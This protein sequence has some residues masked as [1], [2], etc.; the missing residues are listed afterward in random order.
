MPVFGTLTPANTG[1]V[2]VGTD[3]GSPRA[4]QNVIVY[5]GG[6]MRATATIAVRRGCDDELMDTR[7][8]TV[9]ANSVI[10]VNGLSPGENDCTSDRT[11][12]YVRYT[13]ITVDQP[14]LSVVSALAEA[15]PRAPDNV[16]P[17]V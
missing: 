8:V 3:I 15:Q 10:Q 17:L 13:V 16:A 5:N 1:Q 14:S 7:T 11:P 6:S 4:R 9:E 12:A 2:Y